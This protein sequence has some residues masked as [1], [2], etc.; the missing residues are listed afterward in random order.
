M[1][2]TFQ[3]ISKYK[4]TNIGID[5]LY[6]RPVYRKL[7]CISLF[8]LSRSLRENRRSVGQ[9]RQKFPR[10][11]Q[12]TIIRGPNVRNRRYKVFYKYVFQQIKFPLGQCVSTLYRSFLPPKQEAESHG[13][14]DAILL[15]WPAT[16]G[17]TFVSGQVFLAQK[18]KI[19]FFYFC[20]F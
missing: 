17:S 8:Q 6:R 19:S 2:A 9:I 10:S 18:F 14:F 16:S 15:E 1:H 20:I 7:R 5:V 3:L 11:D 13:E 12:K 4:F